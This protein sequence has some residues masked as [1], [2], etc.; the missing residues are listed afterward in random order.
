MNA[1]KHVKKGGTLV[2]SVCSPE[3]EEGRDQIRSFVAQN[4]AFALESELETAPP[5]G[6]I[7][8]F[9]MARMVRK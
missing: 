2:Y 4:P 1:S 3:P 6:D 7:D 5:S 9:Y 8:A